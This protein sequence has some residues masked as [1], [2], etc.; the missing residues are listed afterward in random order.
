M[1]ENEFLRLENVSMTFPGVKALEGVHL[2]IRKGEVHALMG[3]NGAGESTLIKIIAGTQQPDA[4]THQYY[5]SGSVP[6]SQS[7]RCGE[8]LHRLFG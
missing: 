7:E 6:L 5:I 1:Q 3:E 8:H 4:G 2:E